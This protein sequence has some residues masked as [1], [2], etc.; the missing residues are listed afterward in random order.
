MTIDITIL[1]KKV[2]QYVNTND[3]VPGTKKRLLEDTITQPK[4]SKE[5]HHI[6]SY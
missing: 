2:N 6:I 3:N 1:G 5:R 4:M